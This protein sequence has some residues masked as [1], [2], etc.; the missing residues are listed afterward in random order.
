MIF[1]YN[2]LFFSAVTIGFPVI[3]PI[4]L[5]SEKRRKTV[6]QRL[7]LVSKTAKLRQ[8]RLRHSE[9]RPIWVH[10][11]SVGEVLS[12]VPLV[13]GLSK[14]FGHRDIV[15]SV[16]TKTGF[17]IASKYLQEN[18]SSVFFYPYDLPFS[19]KCVVQ[20][21][22]PTI[23]IIVETDIWPNFLFEMKKRNV[24][25]ILANARLSKKSF[26]GYKRFHFF[27]KHVF[28]L[29]AK[30]CTQSK[31]DAQ[32]FWRL[33]VPSSK[34]SVA[35]NFKFDQEY[36]IISSEEKKKLRRSINLQ[37]LQKVLLAGSTHKGEESILL[38]AFS[39]IK[40]EFADL[41]LVVAPRNPDRAKSVCRIFKSAGFSTA[42]MKELENEDP[43]ERLDVV[44]V[45]TIGILKKLY[46]LADVAFVGGSL[47]KCGGHNPIEPA[48]FAKPIIF[49]KDMSDFE[50]VSRILLAS[51]G[52]V[53]V[54][55]A[56]DLYEAI[57]M[58]IG[59]N[60]TAQRMGESAFTIFNA[61]K[62]AVEKTVKV[63][64]SFSQNIKY[65]TNKA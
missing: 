40:K 55:G 8:G 57:T 9:N 52:A 38:D 13:K 29:F 32:R 65:A 3:I 34:I 47:V 23:V 33:G 45:D 56:E 36:D 62:G 58:I 43:S 16:S 63:V 1:L 17:G 2:I 46:A 6:L 18:V 27:M 21:V 31:A 22:N 7:G 12:A 14:R 39:K 53:Q 28:L 48:S 26:S 42:L 50:P 11:L 41:L 19:V 15:V 24:P 10:A 25:V 54:E 61:N 60:N 51:K 20:R 30:V 5:F 44:I 35:G 49:G 37:P 4:V 59:D 64:E